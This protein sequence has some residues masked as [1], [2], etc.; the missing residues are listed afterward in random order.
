MLK[1]Q[2]PKPENPNVMTAGKAELFSKI[3]LSKEKP[4]GNTETVKMKRSSSVLSSASDSSKHSSDMKRKQK[5]VKVQSD[6]ESTQS[7][8]GLFIF[9]LCNLYIHFCM[10]A[11]CFCN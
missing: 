3:A 10:L 6:S 1:I 4:F 8:K 9:N 7:E 2:S 11:V 5:K